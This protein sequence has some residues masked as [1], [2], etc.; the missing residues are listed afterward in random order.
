MYPDPEHC[1]EL[2]Y[3]EERRLPSSLEV[4]IKICSAKKKETVSMHKV[5]YLVFGPYPNPIQ[6]CQV[7]PVSIKYR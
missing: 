1:Q 3:L 7:Y 5:S 2:E 4:K 6:L